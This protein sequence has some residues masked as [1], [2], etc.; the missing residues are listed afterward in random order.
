MIIF[1]VGSLFY[2][3]HSLDPKEITNN[4]TPIIL[5]HGSGANQRQWDFVRQFFKSSETGHVYSL[6]LNDQPFGNDQKSISEYA[7][8]RLKAKVDELKNKYFKAGIRLDEVILVGHSMGSLVGADYAVNYAEESK[9]KVKSLIAISSPWEGSKIADM[10]YD[11]NQKP[12]GAFVTTNDARIDLKNQ[13]LERARAGNINVYT[14]SSSFDPIVRPSSSCL[15]LASEFQ[16]T[17]KIHDHYSTMTD[18]FLAERI[19]EEWI[20]PNTSTLSNT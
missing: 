13:L 16:M 12:E 9:V 4:K 7:Q 19:R 5:I 11:I 17:S 3:S 8:I 20:V 6:N 15:E 18:P 14:F 2:R 1:G 10:L